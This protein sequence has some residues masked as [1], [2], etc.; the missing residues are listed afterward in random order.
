[1]IIHVKEF[2]WNG[3]MLSNLSSSAVDGIDV[4]GPH[5][6]SPPTTPRSRLDV[7]KKAWLTTHGIRYSCF[8]P[9][10]LVFYPKLKV[11]GLGQEY[12]TFSC[13]TQT[14]IPCFPYLRGD[15]RP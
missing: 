14:P 9:L 4:K 6:A 11:E 7:G 5:L 8:I 12:L 15:G 1:M 10:H 2:T 13:P 3:R